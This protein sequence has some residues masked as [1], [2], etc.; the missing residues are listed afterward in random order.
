MV[1]CAISFL[2][3]RNHIPASSSPT[4]T[5]DNNA[6]VT[7]MATTTTQ[8][9][10]TNDPSTIAAVYEDDNTCMVDKLDFPFRTIEISQPINYKMFLYGAGK[11]IYISDAAFNSNG[12]KTFEMHIQ[13]LMYQQLKGRTPNETTI[14]DIGK[15]FLNCFCRVLLFVH[16]ILIQY[17]VRFSSPGANIGTHALHLASNGKLTVLVASTLPLPSCYEMN[18]HLC[19]Y[20]IS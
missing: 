18:S 1:V 20:F 11:D 15:P 5:N 13:Q 12:T 10:A 3:G 19:Q 7:M 8:S 17:H 6:V 4:I 2:M 9:G 16:I 14:I